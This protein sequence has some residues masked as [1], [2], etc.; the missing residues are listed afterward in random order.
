MGID[1]MLTPVTLDPG[2]KSV[3]PA[4]EDLQVN[5]EGLGNSMCNKGISPTSGFD[6]R[7]PRQIYI[8]QTP[9]HII[10]G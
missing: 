1:S 8:P 6:F 2:Q 10:G 4:L 9:S 5:S 3:S 7:S